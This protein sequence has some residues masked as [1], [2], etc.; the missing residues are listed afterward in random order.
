MGEDTS[1]RAC[2][3]APASTP[4]YLALVPHDPGSRRQQRFVPKEPPLAQGGHQAQPVASPPPTARAAAGTV[5]FAP[6]TTPNWH[7]PSPAA[8]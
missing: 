8:V 2:S 5:S 3:S 4:P 6:I 1:T 7:P